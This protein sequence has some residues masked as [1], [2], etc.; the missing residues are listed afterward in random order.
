VLLDPNVPDQAELLEEVAAVVQLTAQLI[1]S[2][3]KSPPAETAI[4]L[5][6]DL[7]HA[8]VPACAAVGGASIFRCAPVSP[9]L[10]RGGHVPSSW[11]DCE[12]T[13]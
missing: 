5:N 6:R 13:V 7:G 9:A 12:C 11:Y 8:P 10:F 2:L 1:A 4:H 3:D